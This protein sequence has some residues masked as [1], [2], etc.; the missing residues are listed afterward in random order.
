M[1]SSIRAV[2]AP[3]S[4]DAYYRT[5]PPDLPS[6]LLKERIVY[7]GLPLFSQDELKQQVG[8]DVTELIIAQLLYLQFDDPDKPV[9]FY[10]N[11]GG[12]IE[13]GTFET[14]AFAICDTLNYIKP[15]VHTIC[16]GQAVGSAAVI[17][18]SGTKGFRGSLPHASIVLN[19]PS[20]GAR[21]QATDIELQVKEA[22]HNKHSM[23]EILARN[24]GKSVESIAQDAD[25]M[26]YMSAHEAKEYGLIDRILENPKELPKIP[27]AVG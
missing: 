7:L 11:S 19:Q 27:A 26:F 23:M 6:L 24:T 12:N 21:G 17:L 14:E 3:Y 22:L 5:P 16:I 18:S 10:I 9:Y 25:R 2:Q 15:P 20:S 1:S 13:G 8:L 4:G